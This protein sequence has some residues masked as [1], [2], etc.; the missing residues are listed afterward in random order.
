M[1]RGAAHTTRPGDGLG[2]ARRYGFS[3]ALWAFERCPRRNLKLLRLV[4]AHRERPDRGPRKGSQSSARMVI[5]LS[6]ALSGRCFSAAAIA[7][8]DSHVDELRKISS[9]SA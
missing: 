3:A 1:S 2:R 5:V 8:Y 4:D 9:R 6:I 7:R